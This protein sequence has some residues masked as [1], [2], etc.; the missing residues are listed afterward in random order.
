[1]AIPFPIHGRARLLLQPAIYFCAG[2]PHAQRYTHRERESLGH[3]SAVGLSII[4]GDAQRIINLRLTGMYI[5]ARRSDRR[6]ARHGK[7]C[8]CHGPDERLEAGRCLEGAGDELWWA[9]EES[10]GGEHYA[11][12]WC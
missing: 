4:N 11:Y 2:G 12:A 10:G 7:P 8:V 6:A 9:E 1:M 3:D 5:A